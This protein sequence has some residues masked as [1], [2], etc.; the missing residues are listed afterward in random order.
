M[1]VG[2]RNWQLELQDMPAFTGTLYMVYKFISF[3]LLF[4]FMLTFQFARHFNQNRKKQT[5]KETKKQDLNPQEN[6]SLINRKKDQP[7]NSVQNMPK[8]ELTLEENQES[9]PDLGLF[10]EEQYSSGILISVA[11]IEMFVGTVLII[12][13]ETIDD[14]F[15]QR[16]SFMMLVSCLI[17]V[18]I[19]YMF[20]LVDKIH[21]Y[22]GGSWLGDDFTV[23]S[24]VIRPF[25]KAKLLAKL[26]LN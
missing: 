1:R 26:G 20:L 21:G 24:G 3:I 7:G 18:G 16:A 17:L 11:I 9:E 2:F 4:A 23:V 10:Q 12:Y 5:Q 14:P 15:H 22:F 6:M 19:L 8:P 25:W 13:L